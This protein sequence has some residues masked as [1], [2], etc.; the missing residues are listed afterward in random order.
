MRRQY[1]I[2]SLLFLLVSCQTTSKGYSVSKRE[3]SNKANSRYETIEKKVDDKLGDSLV[4]LYEDLKKSNEKKED[5]K[6][7]DGNEFIGYYICKL[8]TLDNN[9]FYL[10]N[11][12]ENK[13]IFYTDGVQTNDPFYLVNVKDDTIIDKI[14]NLVKRLEKIF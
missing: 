6:S 8:T 2:T 7:Y 3:F 1:L 5:A 4:I 12:D 11:Q 14:N 10:I 9:Y 13:P